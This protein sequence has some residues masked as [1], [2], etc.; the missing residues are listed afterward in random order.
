M[1]RLMLQEEAGF[2]TKGAFLVWIGPNEKPQL[3]K[4]V[5]LRERLYNYL[6]KN[7]PNI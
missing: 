5:D 7:N 4:T 1:Y 2:E 3:H 6:Q